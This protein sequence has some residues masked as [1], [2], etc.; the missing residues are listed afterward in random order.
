MSTS[1]SITTTTTT[2]T[3][4]TTRSTTTTTT[5][6]TTITTLTTTITTS[7][8]TTTYM[9]GMYIVYYIQEEREY[10]HGGVLRGVH[11]HHP[12]HIREVQASGSNV[13]G[14]QASTLL[15]Q[16]VHVDD[17][18]AL[19]LDLPVQRSECDARLHGAEQVVHE[20]HLYT[21]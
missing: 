21:T 12:V 20:A 18:A 15:P 11:L 4:T 7:T 10:E 9:L 14:E 3:Y 8:T 2:T 13:S 1:T 6:A 17:C 19:L 16:E 5:T